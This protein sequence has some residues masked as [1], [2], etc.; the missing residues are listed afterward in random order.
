[1]RLQCHFEFSR[2]LQ[3]RIVNLLDCINKLPENLSFE[4]EFSRGH[5][6]QV[7]V[8]ITLYYFKNYDPLMRV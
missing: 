3:K 1:M 8:Y 4:A 2:R 7:P 6:N 5:G